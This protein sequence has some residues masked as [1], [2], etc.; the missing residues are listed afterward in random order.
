MVKFYLLDV[1][2]VPQHNRGKKRMVYDKLARIFIAV[3]VVFLLF[4]VSY[5]L[6]I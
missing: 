2:Y 3:A 5:W 6:F 4:G 1:L